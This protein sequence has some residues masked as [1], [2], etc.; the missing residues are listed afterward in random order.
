MKNPLSKKILFL[1]IKN[2]DPDAY[3]QF[4]DLYITRIYRFIYFKV[5]SVNDAQDLTS[6]VF[7]RLWQHIKESREIKNMNA[8]VYMMAR[9]CVIDFY[10]ERTR[11]RE[12]SLESDQVLEIPDEQRDILAQQMKNSDLESILTGLSNLK[13]EYKEVLVLR[14]LDELSITEIADVLGKSKGAVRVLLHR[15]TKTLQNNLR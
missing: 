2:Q 1:K 7:L 13:D 5:N 8:Y 4:Y 11:D 3:S 14:F 6:E 15:A 12:L 10:R 9:N